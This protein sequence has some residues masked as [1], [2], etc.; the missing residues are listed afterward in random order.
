MPTS[1]QT[2][3]TVFAWSPLLAWV[4]LLADG[5]ATRSAPI[6]RSRA[7]DGRIA[8]GYANRRRAFAR[9]GSRQALS[10]QNLAGSI[11]RGATSSTRALECPCPSD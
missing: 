9:V 7:A 10:L 4:Q 1:L 6:V 5:A 2:S 3:S 11:A 8:Q